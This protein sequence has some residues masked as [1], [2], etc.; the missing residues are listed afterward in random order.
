M[1]ER[2]DANLQAMRRLCHDLT[3]AGERGELP[4][5]AMAEFK[6]IVDEARLRLWASMEAAKSGD[7]TWAQEFWLQRAADMCRNASQVLDH[8]SLDRASPRA[9]ELRAAAERLATSL[10]PGQA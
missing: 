9:A 1:S 6:K 7:P 2:P 10:G 4:A 3:A 5:A 8:G